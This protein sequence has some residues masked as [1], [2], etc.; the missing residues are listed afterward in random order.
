MEEVNLVTESLKFMLLG[1]GIVFTFLLLLI[2]LLKLQ[3]FVIQKYFPQN[4]DSNQKD[5][6]KPTQ[7]NSNKA[8]TIAVIS[9]AI[10]HHN[11]VKG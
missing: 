9:A 6:K 2:Q 4:S 8:K 10:E 3:A 1:M 7:N 11:K 5:L